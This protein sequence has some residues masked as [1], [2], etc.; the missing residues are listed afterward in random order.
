MASIQSKAAWADPF[1][2][3][4]VQKYLTRRKYS[5]NSQ[6]SDSGLLFSEQTLMYVCS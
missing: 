1:L 2:P 3:V 5:R 6:N 4:M